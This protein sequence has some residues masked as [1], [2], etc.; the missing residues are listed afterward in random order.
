VPET[1]AWPGP[2]LINVRRSAPNVAEICMIAWYPGLYLEALA[3]IAPSLSALMA[4]AWLVRQRTGNSGWFDTIW[5]FAVGLLSAGR[6][7]WPV[8]ASEL[9]LQ[10][11]RLAGLSGHFPSGFKIFTSSPWTNSLPQIT[12]AVLSASSLPSMPL[13]VPPASRTM[14][15]PA[16]RSHGCRLRS[17]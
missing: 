3:A 7:L 9:F 14:I 11:V 5:T 15:W 13:T 16:A 2:H 6:A 4:I 8:A 10:M 17:Q 1:R 12:L